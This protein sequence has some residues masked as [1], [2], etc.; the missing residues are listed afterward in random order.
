MTNKQ[1][2][3]RT[4][5][6]EVISDKMTKTVIVRVQEF[7]VHPKYQKRYRIYRKY[8]AH[9]EQAGEYK[10]GDRVVIQEH[11][12]MSRTKNWLVVKKA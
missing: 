8:S 1:S 11:R 9:V 5:T 10:V 4:L 7:K 3:K 6:G 2:V 12:P